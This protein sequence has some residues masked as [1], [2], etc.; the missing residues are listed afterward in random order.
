MNF[1]RVLIVLLNFT[2]LASGQGVDDNISGRT[3]VSDQGKLLWTSTARRVAPGSDEWKYECL[4]KNLEKDRTYRVNWEAIPW[5]WSWVR[6]GEEIPVSTY[7]WVGKPERRGGV[8]RYWGGKPG[9]AIEN[10]DIWVPMLPLTSKPSALK[11]KAEI[12]LAS[13][14]ESAEESHRISLVANSKV[15]PGKGQYH[16][17]YTL[18]AANIQELPKD[19]RVR[20][21]S[22]VSS[23]FTKSNEGDF[24]RIAAFNE[25]EF[26]KEIITERELTVRLQSVRFLDSSGVTI[27][28]ALLPAVAPLTLDEKMRE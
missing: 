17:L 9:E 22:I 19:W 26:K 12:R 21:D 18:S 4:L 6:A 11:A 16:I 27:G 15:S 2:W 5:G 13:R 7:T 8:I 23:E 20:W 28:Q 14:S 3:I 10:T 25:S 24:I 1:S